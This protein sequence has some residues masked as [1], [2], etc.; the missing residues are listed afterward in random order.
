M[1]VCVWCV[2]WYQ[3]YQVFLLL[4]PPPV[5][6]QVFRYVCACPRVRAAHDLSQMET[7]SCVS[8]NNGPLMITHPPQ[9]SAPAPLFKTLK[10]ML[11]VVSSVTLL[12]FLC[13]F[14]PCS[15]SLIF[16]CSAQQSAENQCRTFS[17]LH[18]CVH[19]WWHGYVHTGDEHETCLD[20]EAEYRQMT[21]AGD[22]PPCS[23]A[24][25]KRKQGSQSGDTFK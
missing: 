4:L 24:L 5:S 21:L 2:S 25:W 6:W 11:S 16:H 10:D 18:D 3:H 17:T 8:T 15:H 14:F 1:C 9:S 20:K 7:P 23:L 13:S 12:L 22:F 19:T